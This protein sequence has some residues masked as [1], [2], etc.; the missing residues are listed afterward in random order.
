MKRKWTLLFATFVSAGTA[1]Y[2]SRAWEPLLYEFRYIEGFNLLPHRKAD[3]RMQIKTNRLTGRSD[4]EA[5]FLLTEK[6]AYEEQQRLGGHREARWTSDG[7]FIGKSGTGIQWPPGTPK[8][9]GHDPPAWFYDDS[10]FEK[11]E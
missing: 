9:E 5:Y 10:L 1:A 7:A 11:S 8:R 6:K 4:I 3:A 2:F